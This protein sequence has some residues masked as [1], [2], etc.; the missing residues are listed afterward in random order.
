MWHFRCVCC[1][2]ICD[3][4]CEKVTRRKVLDNNR[5]GRDKD[6]FDD[7]MNSES[8]A[9]KPSTCGLLLIN[10]EEKKKSR[11]GQVEVELLSDSRG[12]SWELWMNYVRLSMEHH[13]LCSRLRWSCYE[14]MPIW[15]RMNNGKAAITCVTYSS[16]FSSPVEWYSSSLSIMDPY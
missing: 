5:I 2:L 16:E 9:G 6:R 3:L 1:Y 13:L 8:D 4:G 15:S 14:L 7:S 12:T 10:G 11:L